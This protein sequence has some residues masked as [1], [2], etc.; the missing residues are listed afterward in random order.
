MKKI[1]NSALI[2]IIGGVSGVVCYQFVEKKAEPSFT[3]TSPKTEFRFVSVATPEGAINFKTAAEISV[4]SVVHIK[5]ISQGDNFN[6]NMND[7]FRDFFGPYR[8]NP[9][10]IMG[11]G[12]GVIISENGYIA[13]NNHVVNGADKIEVTLNN[14]KTYTA[15]VIGK[16]P[17]TDLALLKIDEKSLSFLN[18]GNSD[19]VRV[20]EWVLAVGNPF[21]LTSTVTAG[22]IS[23][24]GRNINILENNPEKGIFPI[25]SFIQTDAA[26][27]PGN[28]GG[29]LVNTKGELV[30]INSAIA[31]NT[32]SYSGYSFAVPVNIVKK[33]MNDLLEFGTVQRGFLGV[34]M[35]EIDSKLAEERS[36]KEYK[37]VYV[38]GLVDGGS[39]E[40]AGIKEGDV[41]MKI[42]DV[43]VNNSPELQEQ[44]GKYRPGDKINISLARLGKLMEIPVVLKNKNG[45]TDVVKKEKVESI[46]VLGATFNVPSA[47]EL[48]KLRI[49]NGL[50]VMTLSNGK[51]KNAG[52]REGFI[53][54]H[55]D[56]KPISSVQDISS[57]LD[58]K[59][60]GFLM[61]GIYPN[62]LRAYYGFGL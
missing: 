60:G 4:H 40:L 58:N 59:T 24:K 41:I 1:I 32:G 12:S 48:K 29:A 53:I 6:N 50:K 52:I 57:I 14:N 42:G 49:N 13:T 35:R 51:L 31:S 56:K 47:E 18:Y 45:N 54:T 15:E 36:I 46:N 30:G 26:V 19:E 23:A 16:D 21:N 9:Q 17:T 7:P 27:N 62:G 5:T 10:P 55:V 20:G 61:E 8:G 28:S 43:A 22:I 3:N 25:E 33:V 44:V 2:A 38:S 11:S 34:Y 37:G 39:A